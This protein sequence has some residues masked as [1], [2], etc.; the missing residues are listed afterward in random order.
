MKQDVETWV[1]HCEASQ[2]RK[3]RTDSTTP[4]MKPITPTYLGE[5]WASDVAVL[6]DSKKGNNIEIWRSNKA[7]H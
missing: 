1:K 6:V 3:I 2:R 4:G 7:D 5:I